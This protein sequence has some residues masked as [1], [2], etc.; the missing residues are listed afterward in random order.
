MLAWQRGGR[1]GGYFLCAWIPGLLLTLARALQLALQWPLPAW[2]EFALPAALAFASLVLAFGLAEQTLTVRHERDVA[3]RLAEH[4]MLT[5]VLNRR[6]VL[7]RLRSAFVEARSRRAGLAVLFLDLDHFKRIND[8]FGHR[9]GDQCLRAVIAPIS[10][11]LRQGD[12]LGRWGGE[13]FLVVLPGV[14]AARAGAVAERIRACI[15]K[16]P[17]LVSGARVGLTMSIGIAA[18]DEHVST[19]EDLIEGADLA[20]YRAKAEGRNRVCL[21]AD[22]GAAPEAPDEART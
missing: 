14:D 22:E 20:L 13:E 15:E 5:G 1:R 2:L 4:D 8:S 6:A 17:L 11:E 16:L 7:A 21:H 10:G 19:P 12:A 9:T 3:H 18:L